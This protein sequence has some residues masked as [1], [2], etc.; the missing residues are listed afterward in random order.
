MASLVDGI[1][2]HYISTDV[3]HHGL[4]SGQDPYQ[5]N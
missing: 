3:A 5:Q 1:D 4:E 2:G